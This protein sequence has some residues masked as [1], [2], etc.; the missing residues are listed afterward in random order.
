MQKM[1]KASEFIARMQSLIAIHGGDP[2]I[3]VT[4]SGDSGIDY[5]PAVMDLLNC[6]AVAGGYVYSEK[7]CD[8]QV[9]HIW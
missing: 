9:I 7:D 6:K 5:E 4:S 2:D 3:A 1:T 8:T